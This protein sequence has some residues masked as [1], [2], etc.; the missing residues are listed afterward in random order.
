MSGP[1]FGDDQPEPDERP[2]AIPDHARERLA[3]VAAGR[4]PFTSTLSANAFAAL[5]GADIQPLCQ[6]MGSS[7]Y[8]VGWQITGW[9]RLNALRN[10]GYGTYRP[11]GSRPGIDRTTGLPLRLS[12]Y[13][14][15][16]ELRTLGAAYNDARDRALAR[17][18]QEARLAGADAVVDVEVVQHPFGG[19]RDVIE[20]RAMGTAVRAPGL[21]GDA[22]PAFV[23]LTGQDVGV[24]LRGG[25]RPVGLV[26]ATS[27]YLGTASLD[28]V[29]E[30]RSLTGKRWRNFEYAEF[31]DAWAYARNRALMHMRAQASDLGADGIIGIRWT[32]ET[33]EQD[34]EDSDYRFPGLIYVVHAIGTAIAGPAADGTPDVYTV[35]P[36]ADRPG[37]QEAS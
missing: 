19:R 1:F 35:M 10:Q 37:T 7:V 24:L 15:P 21:R 33:R 25:Q 22:G 3:G 6:V 8:H 26:T 34:I 2:A 36:M 12:W 9:G 5:R 14:T 4:V 11:D 17:L 31:A 30:L 23:N 27:A 16:Q 13:G 20:F 29:I 28:T 18:S 32:Q